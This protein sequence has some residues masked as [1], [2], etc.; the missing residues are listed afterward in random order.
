MPSYAC[1]NGLAFGQRYSTSCAVASN[2]DIILIMKPTAHSTLA[3]SIVEMALLI[4]LGAI[5]AM[6]AMRFAGK[7]NADTLCKAGGA[8][9]GE[10]RELEYSEEFRC[11]GHS[12]TAFGA[13]G[14]ACIS[15]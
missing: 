11:C 4:T 13:T 3:A 6:S 7:E 5:I 10:R 15:N 2:A 9:D 14:F 8:V 1:R 12:I